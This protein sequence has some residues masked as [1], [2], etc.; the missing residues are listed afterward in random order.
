MAA[1]RKALERQLENRTYQMEAELTLIV[2]KESKATIVCFLFSLQVLLVSTIRC[3]NLL[4][5][6]LQQNNG[7]LTTPHRAAIRV[8]LKEQSSPFILLV[9]QLVA[10]TVVYPPSIY[11]HCRRHQ[12]S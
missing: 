6:C 12:L 11:G 7:L 1:K 2:K 9:R 8:W 10:K 3:C 4:F 5:E